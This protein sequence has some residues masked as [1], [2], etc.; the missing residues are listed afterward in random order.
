MTPE[1][2]AAAQRAISTA[3]SA[4]RLAADV[5]A[6]LVP[7]QAQVPEGITVHV[8]PI[9]GRSTRRGDG[10]SVAIW[11]V[12]VAIYGRELAVEQWTTAAYSMVWEA[13]GWRMDEL[14][15]TPGPHPTR[16]AATT[17]TPVGQLLAALNGFTDEGG[18]AVIFAIDLNPVDD[19]IDGV[20]DLLGGAAEAAGE[21][22]LDVVVK[23]VFGLIA[24]AVT[25][26]TSSIVSAMNAT[27]GVDFDGGF[28][29]R[30]PN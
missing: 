30:L 13:G 9:A 22:V 10:W 11:Y 5:Q 15:S 18:D 29:R 28:F 4:D 24:N 23:F 6:K 14:V 19:V 1:E 17:A 27:T 26:I 12:Q 2:G 8:A 21:A 16:P 7:I 3:R 20:G 25:S